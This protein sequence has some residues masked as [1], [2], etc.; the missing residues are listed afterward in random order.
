METKQP[1]K[2]TRI[3]KV[4]PQTLQDL[5]RFILW[6]KS[7][8]VSRIK[9][10]DIEVQLLDVAVIHAVESKLSET[11]ASQPLIVAGAEERDTGRTMVDEA[12]ASKSEE[13]ELLYWSANSP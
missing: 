11:V 9:L 6:A 12:D 2:R 3:N 7:E 4:A 5:Q 13:E 8:G 1:K 10:G